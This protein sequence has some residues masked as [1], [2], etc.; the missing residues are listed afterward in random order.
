MEE[1]WDLYLDKG[2]IRSTEAPGPILGPGPEQGP[3]RQERNGAGEWWDN[4]VV[5]SKDH[6]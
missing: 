1:L 3:I 4:S 5:D 6:L 2:V